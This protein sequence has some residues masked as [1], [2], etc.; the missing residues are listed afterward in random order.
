MDD[1]LNILLA[2]P[3]GGAQPAIEE[4]GIAA[5]RALDGR[6][7]IRFGNYFESSEIRTARG[8]PPYDEARRMTPPPTAEQ[9]EAFGWAHVILGI[10]LPFD[11]D[12]IAPNLRWVQALPAGIAHLQ[13]AGLEKRGVLLSSGAGLVSDPIA[14]FVLA[15]ILAHWKLL[16][17][18]DRLQKEH[19]WR[20]THGRNLAGSTLGIVGF[21]AI[22]SAIATRAK[23]LGMHVLVTRRHLAPGAAHPAVDRFYALSEL[24]T[25]LACSDAVALCAS[26]TPETRHMFNETT[27]AAMKT[28]SF[29]CNVARGSLVDE[30]ALRKTLA[31]GHLGAAAID[32]AAREP[33]PPEDPLWDTPNLFISPHSS[34]SI[35]RIFESIW[36]LFLE[37]MKRYLAGTPLKNACNPGFS[38]G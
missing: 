2:Y 31:E 35:E 22:G 7:R 38:R 29:F 30:A 6:T 36:A 27:F 34:A 10:D 11:M 8:Q 4:A 17:L 28:G 18:F 25:L 3:R 21:G 37:N 9:R 14:E 16:P 1:T 12:V 5:L 13:S 23:A 33:L 32:V 20:P 15:R 19:R 24:H 26:E